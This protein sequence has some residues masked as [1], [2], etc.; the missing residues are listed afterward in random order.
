[1]TEHLELLLVSYSDRPKIL[2]GVMV[3]VP[4]KPFWRPIGSFIKKV[5][6]DPIP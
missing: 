2:N 4:N 3:D 6:K 5:H 1:M